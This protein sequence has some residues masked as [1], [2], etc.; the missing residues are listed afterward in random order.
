MCTPQYSFNAKISNTAGSGESAYYKGVGGKEPR[1]VVVWKVP[2]QLL[3]CVHRRNKPPRL[4]RMPMM[5]SQ[6]TGYLKNKI[7]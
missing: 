6:R 2:P 4:K 3:S 7:V 5:Q 1:S